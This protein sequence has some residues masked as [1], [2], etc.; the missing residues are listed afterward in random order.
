MNKDMKILVVA[1]YDSVK[2]MLREILSVYEQVR[3]TTS[4][5]VKKKLTALDPMSF[6][7]CSRKTEQE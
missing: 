6:C 7:S 5:E 1:D 4:S 3:Y 2:D